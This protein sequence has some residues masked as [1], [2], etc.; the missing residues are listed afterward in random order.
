MALLNPTAHRAR[1][2]AG[3]SVAHTQSLISNLN[4]GIVERPAAMVGKHVEVEGEVIAFITFNEG[5]AKDV[6]IISY[7]SATIEQLR[8]IVIPRFDRF[9]V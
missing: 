5:A 8:T 4:A 3:D 6:E 9:F 2:T 1:W 7:L